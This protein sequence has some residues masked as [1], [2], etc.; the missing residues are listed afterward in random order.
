MIQLQDQPHF[1]Q[2]VGL[3]ASQGCFHPEQFFDTEHVQTIAGRR[4]E[5]SVLAHKAGVLSS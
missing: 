5:S 2:E 1:E 4:E 3:G